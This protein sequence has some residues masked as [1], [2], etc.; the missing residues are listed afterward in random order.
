MFLLYS[1][2][3]AFVIL[4]GSPY[5]LLQGLLHKKYLTSLPQRLGFLSAEIESLPPRRIWIH[6]V[7]VGEVLAVLPL[8]WKIK[9]KW[10][11]HALLISTTTLTGQA[12]ARNKLH[13][14]ATCFFF[15]L[16]FNNVVRRVL[17]HVRP[18][19][20]LIA[21]T[22]IWPNFLRECQQQAIPVLLVNGRISDQSFRNYRRIAAVTRRVLPGFTACLMQTSVD[23]DRLL[24][25]GA[26]PERV[27]A[28]GN[29]KY[30]L[31]LPA[32]LE[33][34]SVFF[35]NL[36]SLNRYRFV[37]VAGSTLKGEEEP[38]LKA[39][40][41]FR[42]V[43]PESLLILAPRH[44]ER[45]EEVAAV[46]REQSLHFVRRSQLPSTALGGEIP[47]PEA[48][49]LDTIGELA[50]LYARADVVF[51]GGSLVPRGGHNILE[52][53]LHRKPVL[54][55]PHM[56]NFRQMA[57][58]FLE[59]RAGCVVRDENELH[60]SW[61]RL[62]RDPDLRRSMGEKGFSI[63]AA[64]RGTAGRII[65]RMSRIVQY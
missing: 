33:R 53:A 10:P 35:E 58:L 55:G 63:I 21:E 18:E 39:F 64:N 52:P 32:D 56:N 49:L 2:L 59:A 54:F 20:V 46:F 27:E 34:N 16:D 26:P 19:L 11:G 24:E 5:F 13:G 37:L 57:S 28:C 25:L 45:F 17:R 23:C 47:L 38:V 62:Y 3:F 30:D 31:D 4:L 12:L 8:I 61:V 9:E 22:E 51:V 65:Q 41:K 48:V 36:F 43:E 60:E 1:V 7:S 50:T 6:A 29:L 15:P 40:Q 42:K 44:P 14:L